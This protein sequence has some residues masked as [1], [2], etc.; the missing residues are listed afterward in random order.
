METLRNRK[1]LVQALPRDGVVAEVGVQRGRFAKVIWRYARP[2]RLHLIDCWEQQDD[3]R[4][5]ADAANVNGHRQEDNYR[6]T[7]QRLARAIAKNRVVLHRGYSV[8]TLQTFPNEYFDWIYIDANHTYEAVKADL[9]ACRRKVKEA[10][11]IGGHDYIDSAFWKERN[12]GV[13]EAVDEF[14]QNHGWE[15]VYLTAEPGNEIN[16]R[17]NPSFALRRIGAPPLSQ[18]Q[19]FWW[20]GSINRRAA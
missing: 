8:P 14:C 19:R 18:T 5:Q 11:V 13:V 6:R 4:Y 9:E 16:R 10:G 1:R 15:I 7:K 2:R 3:E 20:P 17:G 12:Y